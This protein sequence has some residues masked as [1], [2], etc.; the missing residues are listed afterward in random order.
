[1]TATTLNTSSE[2]ALVFAATG[3]AA[4]AVGNRLA[5]NWT[6]DAEL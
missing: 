4:T 1:L 5:V 2:K 6:A 3:N